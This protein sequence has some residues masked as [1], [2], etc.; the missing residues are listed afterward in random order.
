MDKRS[1]G[2]AARVLTY[3][4]GQFFSSGTSRRLIQ[5]P[6]R[7]EFRILMA[8]PVK[9]VA[10]VP[11]ELSP[12]ESGR[13]WRWKDRLA[14]NTNLPRQVDRISLGSLFFRRGHCV[15]SSVSVFKLT[16]R[17]VFVSTLHPSMNEYPENI[18]LER[19]RESCIYC[20]IDRPPVILS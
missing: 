11:D 18:I 4:T 8:W 6:R 5:N 2:L 12:K 7:R 16:L 14:R 15:G 10:H 13:T 9:G 3:A 1:V 20:G 17:S 19:S